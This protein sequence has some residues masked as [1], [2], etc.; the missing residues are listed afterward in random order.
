MVNKHAL[1][2]YNKVNT[3]SAVAS[4]NPHRLVQMLMEG[5]L[6]RVA[7]A[8][9]AIKR[10]NS[11][12]RG[13]AI[14]K[15][16]SIVGGLREGLNHEAG[17]EV[18]SNLEALY[19]FMQAELIKANRNSDPDLLDEVAALMRSVKEGWDGIAPKE[20]VVAE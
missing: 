3:E 7:E 4:A 13:E 19:V 9:G 2:S 16:I 20:A 14:G 8:Q 12:V 11:S 17:G 10:N 15:A 6:Q 5:L 1:S 18:V